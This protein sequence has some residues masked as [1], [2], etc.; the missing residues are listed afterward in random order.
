MKAGPKPGLVPNAKAGPAKEVVVTLE[1]SPIGRIPAH[2]GTLRALGLRKRGATRKHKLT[3][4][5]VGMLR[6]VGYLVKVEDA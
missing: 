4:V 6:Q 2:R 3:P 5:I 1:K